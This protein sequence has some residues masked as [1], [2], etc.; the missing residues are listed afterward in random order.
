MADDMK[1]ATVDQLLAEAAWLRALARSLLHG[2]VSVDDAVQ[3]VWLAALRSPPE[4]AR[5]PRPWLAQVLR[6]VVRSA[7]RRFRTQRAQE[8]EAVRRAAALV[9]SAESALE[10][11]ELEHALVT[12]VLRLTEPYRRTLLLHFYQG[13]R[14]VDI[15]RAEGVP[16]GTVRWRINEGLRRL[17]AGLDAAPAAKRARVKCALAALASPA[18][19]RVQPPPRWLPAGRAAGGTLA[20]AGG[21]LLAVT[22]I[23]GTLAIASFRAPPRAT[24]SLSDGPT[25]AA[26]LREG[27][28][29][30]REKLKRAA[31]FFG[32]ALPALAAAADEAALEAEV[33]SACLEMQ[34]RAFECKDAFVDTVLD[35]QLALTGDHLTPAERLPV[36]EARLRVYKQ[37]AERPLD[38]RRAGC[39]SFIDRLDRPTRAVA[40]IHSRPLRSCLASAECSARATCAVSVFADI[41]GALA[42]AP[43]DAMPL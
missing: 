29:A 18:P 7:A 32:V 36:R 3:E 14:A 16:A 4:R 42:A 6:N 26:P 12:G 19:R 2:S 8:A 33:I 1:V 37:E 43:G 5:P 25:V 15:A 10:H 28:A 17:R 31:V 27:A 30:R 20:L 24:G 39:K 11:Q 13:R 22:L 23:V 21:G 35:H 9:L 40:K 34:E 41:A 38:Q